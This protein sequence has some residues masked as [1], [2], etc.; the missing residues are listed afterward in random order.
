MIS[1][2][3]SCLF[4]LTNFEHNIHIEIYL[5]FISIEIQSSL[6][7]NPNDKK[8]SRKFPV[9]SAVRIFHRSKQRQLDNIFVE[10]FLFAEDHHYRP[11]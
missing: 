11:D 2:K 5:F 6:E 10:N 8:H 1:L 4:L 9:T 3:V 7:S